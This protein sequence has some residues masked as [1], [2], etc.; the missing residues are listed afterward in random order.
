[1]WKDVVGF[2]GKY[3]V[4]D[5]GEVMSF[6][7]SNSGKILKPVKSK[8]TGYLH[9]NLGRNYR[10]TVHRLVAEAFIP[11]PDNLPCVNHKDENKLNNNVDN[12]EWASYQYNLAYSDV[13]NRAKVTRG[14]TSGCRNSF[15]GKHHTDATKELC[16]KATRGKVYVNDGE[17]EFAISKN[18]LQKYLDMGYNRGYIRRK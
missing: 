17:R 9:I 14:D 15:Y 11:N 18:D 16:G 13:W 10:T 12:L 5:S 2:N 4:S 8:T 3:R 1:M 7:R 6:A